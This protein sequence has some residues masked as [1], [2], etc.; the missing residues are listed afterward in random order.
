L[1]KPEEVGLPDASIPKGLTVIKDARGYLWD[2]VSYFW[3]ESWISNGVIFR[4]SLMA[5]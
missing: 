1:K 2:S 4:R 5:H 3:T